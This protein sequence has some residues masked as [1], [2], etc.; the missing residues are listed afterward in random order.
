MVPNVWIY[1]FKL[2]KTMATMGGYY[3]GALSWLVHTVAAVAAVAAW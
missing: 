1:T 3:R 2:F